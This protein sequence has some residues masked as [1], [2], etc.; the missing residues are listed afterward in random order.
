MSRIL[1]F[2]DSIAWG[3]WD[4]EGGWAQ[5]LRRFLDLENIFDPDLYYAVYNL[6]ISGDI[7]KGVLKRIESETKQRTNEKDEIIYIFA[8]GMNDT[9]FLSSKNSI[10]VKPAEFKENI[11]KIIKIAKKYS[12]KIMFVGLT[13]VDEARTKPMQDNKE[14]SFRNEHIKQYDKIIKNVCNENKVL[15]ME[16]PVMDKYTLE[17]GLHPNDRGHEMI[18]ES[19]K[20]FLTKNKLVS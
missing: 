1:V 7:T 9:Q 14:V 18:F 4:T 2:G 8:I 5:R 20:N 19:V 17:D 11:T 12:K 3:M 10:R 16:A 15:F 6:G 13:S